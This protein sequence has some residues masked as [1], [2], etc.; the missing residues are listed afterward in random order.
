V[1]LGNGGFEIVGTARGLASGWTSTI[2]A[3]IEEFAA[4]GLDP[5]TDDESPQETFEDGWAA[6]PL[7]T[8]SQVVLANEVQQAHTDYVAF[9]EQLVV[10]LNGVVVMS[11]GVGSTKHDLDFLPVFPT[12]SV[13]ALY[14]TAGVATD[15]ENFGQFWLIHPDAVPPAPTV[16]PPV[17]T[18][19]VPGLELAAYDSAAPVSQAAQEFEDCED[20]WIAEPQD[21]PIAGPVFSVIVFDDGVDLT[22]ASYNSIPNQAPVD[23]FDFAWGNNLV[24][25]QL[26]ANDD[27]I[28]VAEASW[29]Y[30]SPSGLVGSRAFEDFER[31][32]LPTLMSQ[33]VPSTEVL[34][35][36]F[37]NS[38]HVDTDVVVDTNLD[39]FLAYVPTSTAAPVEIQSTGDMPGGITA[40]TAYYVVSP[41]VEN[42]KL[43]S[44][45][46]GTPIL[47]ITSTGTGDRSWTYTR[48]LIWTRA[49]G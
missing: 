40:G 23:A 11:A 9:S 25:I 45:S 18:I 17:Q 43:S 29:G 10:E 38:R 15:V 4:F 5:S 14:N 33:V 41:T 1:S 16:M 48:A 13:A 27:G 36:L 46:T 21:N 7:S 3:T 35:P 2:V 32:Q 26:G 8:S 39:V 28:V 34:W 31:L 42:F 47:D 49:L 37:D 19:A 20:H 30:L 44:N 24:P 22:F 6:F 12:S